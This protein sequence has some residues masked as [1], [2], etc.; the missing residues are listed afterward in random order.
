MH[1]WEQIFKVPE[2]ETCYYATNGKP[3]TG[4]GIAYW[5]D[6]LRIPVEDGPLQDV[7]L[8]EF[9]GEV[10]GT[11]GY[12]KTNLNYATREEIDEARSKEQARIDAAI[13][14]IDRESENNQNAGN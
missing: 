10:Y 11:Y 8:V 1:N 6:D 7:V 2:G 13:E 9:I 14:Q 4:G 3:Y 12:I 5:M